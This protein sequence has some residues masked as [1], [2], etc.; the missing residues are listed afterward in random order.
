MHYIRVIPLLSL[1][2]LLSTAAAAQPFNPP[3]PILGVNPGD[4]F[5]T[6]IAAGNVNGNV[7]GDVLVRRGSSFLSADEPGENTE[8]DLFLGASGFPAPGL[9]AAA[10]AL[11]FSNPSDGDHNYGYSFALGDL[12]GDGFD[13]VIIGA[14]GDDTNGIL[15]GAV[16][17]YCGGPAMDTTPDVIIY[18]PVNPATESGEFGD[19]FRMAIGTDLAVGDV[20]GD[21]ITDLVVLGHFRFSTLGATYVFPGAGDFCDGVPRVLQADVDATA[22]IEIRPASGLFTTFFLRLGDLNGD[23]L[24]D[25]AVLD[26]TDDSKLNLP[27]E[28]GSMIDGVLYVFYSSPVL[29]A[30]REA[31]DADLYIVGAGLFDE[32]DEYE[33]GF[34]PSLLSLDGPFAIG[35]LN[36]DGNGD[37]SIAGR[38]LDPVDYST[39][40]HLV[41]VF[42]GGGTLP[43]LVLAVDADARVEL[44]ARHLAIGDP[45]GDGTDDLL[46]SSAG[47]TFY[48]FTGGAPFPASL[49]AS[50]R[51]YTLPGGPFAVLTNPDAGTCP[52]LG[53][54]D[55]EFSSERGRARVYTCPA[56]DTTPP[57]CG[58]IVVERDA[59]GRLTAVASSA[60]DPESGIMGLVFTRLQNL[61]GFAQGEGPYVQGNSAW[62]PQPYPTTV[63]FRG[64]RISFSA[65]GA[66]LVTVYN[67]VQ[68]SA[69]CD[70][71]IAQLSATA[72]E[73]TS[74]SVPYPNPASGPVVF[75]FALAEPGTV[76]L[77][78]YDVAGREVARLVESEMETGHYEAT[79]AAQDLAAGTYVVRLTAGHSVHTQRLTLVR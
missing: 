50:A 21:G 61:R 72:P 37:I 18:G 52:G 12:T 53:V 39:A 77:T 42:Y 78:V 62:F 30:F 36:G 32:S 20:T 79:W 17:I 48:A 64:E 33:E 76:A 40:E 1:A 55:P 71:V 43:Q 47:G 24:L 35:D 73:A 7:F 65:G 16:Y 25:V 45:D 46:A 60:S 69:V 13:E 14:P 4:A 63:S 10:A 5:G 29:P 22:R 11:T 19:E 56:V 44:H 6:A 68:L 2:V 23:G 74:L 51:A 49:P 75:R 57:E 58:R 26:N 31:T 8:L 59:Q 28:P 3:A 9:T 70:P 38:R 66:L 15:S 34:A 67:G 27:D 41:F 54:G